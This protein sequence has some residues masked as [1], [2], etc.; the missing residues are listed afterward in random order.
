MF[1]FKFF[2]SFVVVV[3]IFTLLGVPE[4]TFALDV[5]HDLALPSATD[6]IV[7]KSFTFNLMQ[8]NGHLMSTVK[9]AVRGV[10][11]PVYPY[12]SAISRMTAS[13]AGHGDS[14]FSFTQ[15]V[16]GQYGTIHIRFPSYNTIQHLK[17]HISLGGAISFVNSW[18]SIY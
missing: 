1:K 2:V 6:T 3:L 8:N 9:I 5:A 18:K 4:Q 11:S 10:Y 12:S 17:F 15:T 14:N 7:N 13:F 16:Y